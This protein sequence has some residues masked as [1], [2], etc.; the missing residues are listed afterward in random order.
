MARSAAFL[1][2]ASLLL[3]AANGQ[4]PGCKESTNYIVL[5][6]LAHPVHQATN[7]HNCGNWGEPANATACPDLESCAKNCIMDPVSDYSKYGIQTDGSSL[8]LQQILDGK[9]VS[10]RV[11]L[12]DETERRY[13]MLSLTGNEFTFDVDATKL[14]CGMNSALYL[15]EM[16]PT[17]AQST[18]NPG[19]AYMGTGYC[20]AQ[21]YTTPFINGLVGFPSLTLVQPQQQMLTMTRATSTARAR[22]ATR[23]TSGRPTRGPTT[24]RRTRAAPRAPTSARAPTAKTTACATRTAARGTRTA[25]T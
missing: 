5:D 2:L 6:A 11:Y 9:V 13:E 19:G 23:W 24:S 21:C 3:G 7:S 14:P 12:L 25:S 17:G 20:D 16:H 1:G 10:P 18:L 4:M 22:A 8:R 15:S